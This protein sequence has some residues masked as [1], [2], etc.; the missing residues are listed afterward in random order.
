[1]FLTAN[2]EYAALNDQSF[3][4]LNGVLSSVKS[5][6]EFPPAMKH[7]IPFYVRR[8]GSYNKINL[9]IVTGGGDCRHSLKRSFEDFFRASGIHDGP[10]LWGRDYFPDEE[11]NSDG[12]K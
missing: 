9:N 6:T 4:L 10:F 12:A 11:D 2:T 3:Q 7:N 1:V 8:E 5:T